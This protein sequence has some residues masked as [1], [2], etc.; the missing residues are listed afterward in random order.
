M[1]GQLAL[2]PITQIRTHQTAG[3]TEM[4]PNPTAARLTDRDRRHI[5]EARELAALC[6][7]AAV[8]QR[9]PGWNDTAAAY[10]EVFGYARWHMEELADLAERLADTTPEA[11]K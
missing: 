8:A 10:A 1:G 3:R 4:K 6:T 7:T 9:F 2:P 11:A 5:T